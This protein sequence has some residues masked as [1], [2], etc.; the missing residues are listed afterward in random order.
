MDIFTTEFSFRFY[1]NLNFMWGDFHDRIFDS[2]YNFTTNIF[3]RLTDS[4]FRKILQTFRFF[5]LQLHKFAIGKR[6]KYEKH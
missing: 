5:E 3:V 4:N 2:L 6:I 1:L